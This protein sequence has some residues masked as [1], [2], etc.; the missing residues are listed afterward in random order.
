MNRPS[1]AMIGG[2][3][4]PVARADALQLG[5]FAASRRDARDAPYLENQSKTVRRPSKRK[6][7]REGFVG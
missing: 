2:G 4:L 6:Q 7:K 3:V 5:A 1:C